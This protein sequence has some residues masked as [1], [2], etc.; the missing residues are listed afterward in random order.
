V[1]HYGYKASDNAS[2]YWVHF[3]ADKNKFPIPCGIYN[4]MERLSLFK[5]L[6][7]LANLPH[8]PSYAVNAVLVHILSLF[9]M[10][11]EKS[12][13]DSDRLAEEIHEWIRI[14]ADA[15]L[16]AAKISDHF[17]FCTDHI[18]R[19]LQKS[20]GMGTKELINKFIIAKAKELLLNTGKL[21]SEYYEAMI[22]KSETL[23][24]NGDDEKPPALLAERI[25]NYLDQEYIH[26]AKLSRVATRFFVNPS[27]ASRTFSRQYG[28]SIVDYVNRLKIDRA[29]LLLSTTDIPLGSIALNVGFSDANYFSRLFKKN[30]GISPR[31]YR[32]KKR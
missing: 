8:S 28:V 3:H 1:R 24:L 15:T 21:L 31:E 7:H 23:N 32:S 2:F 26:G 5:E 25:K 4:G 9:L 6:L 14:N 20:T 10:D 30:V 27:Y 29:K 19:I 16:S 13:S 22:T 17:G 12:N 18:T 11:F